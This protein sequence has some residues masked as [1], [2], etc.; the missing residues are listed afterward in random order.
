[1]HSCLN[2]VSSLAYRSGTCALISVPLSVCSYKVNIQNVENDY[3]TE[4][5]TKRK[6]KQDS[7]I[8]NQHSRDTYRSLHHS[9]LVYGA[10]KLPFFKRDQGFHPYHRVLLNKI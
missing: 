5:H 3:V 6:E 4:T 2:G 1:M 7:R 10:E 9:N 8:K